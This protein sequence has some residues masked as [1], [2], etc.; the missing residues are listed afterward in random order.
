MRFVLLLLLWLLGQWPHVDRQAHLEAKYSEM[1][2]FPTSMEMRVGGRKPMFMGNLGSGLDVHSTIA[3]VGGRGEDVQLPAK[4]E[5][6]F[7]CWVSI[8]QSLLWLHHTAALAG[9]ST[10]ERNPTKG[11]SS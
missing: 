4:A 10:M 6:G 8:A 2:E 1:L 11:V 5:P 9:L 3:R 7:V